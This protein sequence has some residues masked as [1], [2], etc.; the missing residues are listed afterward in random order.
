MCDLAEAPT[1]SDFILSEMESLKPGAEYGYIPFDIFA[2]EEWDYSQPRDT[3]AEQWTILV[4][5]YLSLEPLQRK[6]IQERNIC[7]SKYG[8]ATLVWVRTCYEPAL[9]DQYQDLKEEWAC[10]GGGLGG[11]CPEEYYLLEDAAL[12]DAGPDYGRD[13]ILRTVMTRLP[14]LSDF[15]WSPQD[16]EWREKELKEIEE[17]EESISNAKLLRASLDAEA[18]LYILDA[19]AIQENLV[20]LMWLD[21]HGN[22]VWNNK[23]EPDT[24]DG[25]RAMFSRGYTLFEATESHC[26]IS[27]EEDDE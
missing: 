19:E 1:T 18:L 15:L 13:R 22:S 27:N 10:E 7:V 26:I 16:I 5:R 14:T 6:T 20:K 4:R 12:Y 9:E 8:I 2:L 25:M 24:M 17:E 23:I 3:D 11:A 21:T